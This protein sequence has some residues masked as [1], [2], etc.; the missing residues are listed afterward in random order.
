MTDP[1][2]ALAADGKDAAAVEQ[3]LGYEEGEKR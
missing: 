3:R 1:K 2:Q